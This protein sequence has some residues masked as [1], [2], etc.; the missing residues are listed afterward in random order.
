MAGVADYLD[1]LKALLPQGV[2]WTREADSTLSAVL[3]GVAAELARADER[4]RDLMVQTDPRVV[5]EMLADWEQAWGLPDGCV[6]AEPT[7]AGRR[8]ALHQ[9][10]ASLGGQSAS[11]YVGLAAMLGYD[12]D[13]ETFRPTRLPFTIAAPIMGRPWA[14]AWKLAVYGPIGDVPVYA[15]ADLA[16]V[17][18]R[19]KP[20]HTVVSFDYSPDPE[21][22]FYFDFLNPPEA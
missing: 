18:G 9:R 3:E 21:P 2:A 13:V 1:Q 19:L 16:C 17:I 5:T 14:F 8:L 11:Y 22:T 4:G 7:E 15:S 20:G 6:S 12:V 10:V